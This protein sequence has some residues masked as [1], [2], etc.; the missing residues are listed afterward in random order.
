PP[1]DSAAAEL[2][3]LEAARSVT[4][5]AGTV[6]RNRAGEAGLSRLTDFEIPFEAR[7][8]VG[9]GKIVVGGTPPVRAAG[10]PAGAGAPPP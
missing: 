9:D 7:F 3:E 6:F 10:A 1:A 2:R 4:L 8:P 5:T